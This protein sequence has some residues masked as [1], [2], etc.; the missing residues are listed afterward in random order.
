[1][2]GLQFH[3]GGKFLIS[4]SDDKTLRAWD[5]KNQRCAKTLV[6]HEH[7]CTTF[8]KSINVIVEE[9]GYCS[10]FLQM[11]YAALQNVTYKLHKKKNC[12]IIQYSSSRQLYIQS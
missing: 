1:M 9:V 7:F 2:R 8:G 11:I 5:V 3:P 12:K 6:V 10:F 4:C